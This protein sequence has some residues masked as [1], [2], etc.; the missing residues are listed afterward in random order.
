MTGD[1]AAAG[2]DLADGYQV[3]V[4]GCLSEDLLAWLDLTGTYDQS[5]D[6]T[7]LLVTT[8]DQAVL[9][10]LLHRLCDLGLTLISVR[11][12]PVQPS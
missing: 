4:K 3:R 8:T 9:Y 2:H 6:E 1:L 7:V 5:L 10:G 12:H 11:T